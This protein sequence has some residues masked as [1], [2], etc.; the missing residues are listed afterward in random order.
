MWQT[1]SNSFV[2][3]QIQAPPVCL[4]SATSSYTNNLL[5]R[6]GWT[7][8]LLDMDLCRGEDGQ[9]EG[10]RLV[11]FVGGRHNQVFT[12]LQFCELHDLTCI[13]VDLRFHDRHVR[14]EERG[15]ELPF[16]RLVL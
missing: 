11:G 3:L 1:E 7:D 4:I 5:T 9:D 12:R 14:F 6:S 15:R 2:S 13:L 10:G 8:C 16:H